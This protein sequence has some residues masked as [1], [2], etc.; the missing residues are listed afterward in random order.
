MRPMEIAARRRTSGC[1]DLRILPSAASSYY[2]VSSSLSSVAIASMSARAKGRRCAC[3]DT[4][5]P[6]KATTTRIFRIARFYAA[7][8][9][10]NEEDVRMQIPRT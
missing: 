6:H 9:E 5:A 1:A 4:A 8:N 7:G 10:E 3:T 2:R